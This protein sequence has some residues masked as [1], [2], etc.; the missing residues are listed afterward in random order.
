MKKLAAEIFL[1]A[2]DDYKNKIDNAEANFREALEFLTGRTIWHEIL[3][4]NPEAIKLK[5]GG[6]NERSG[7]NSR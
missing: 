2:L 4:I 7:H 1:S 3:G 5:L 6:L